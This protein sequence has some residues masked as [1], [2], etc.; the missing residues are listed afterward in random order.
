MIYFPGN[1]E[2]EVRGVSKLG[3]IGIDFKDLMQL[4]LMFMLINCYGV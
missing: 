4:I 1:L 2:L 3:I